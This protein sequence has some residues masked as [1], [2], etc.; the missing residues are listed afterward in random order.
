MTRAEAIR[1]I[2]DALREATWLPDSME[3]IVV[4]AIDRGR[5]GPKVLVRPEVKA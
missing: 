2:A 5:D 4:E 3:K 1:A